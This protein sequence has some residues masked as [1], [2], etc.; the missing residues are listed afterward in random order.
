MSRRRR[1]FTLIELL[2]VIAI[3]AVLIAL[4]LP[5]V[6]AAR[7]AARRA[8]CVN[9][10]KQIGLGLHNYL[11]THNS[12]PLGSIY[13]PTTGPGVYGGQP[14]SIHAQ[15][16]GYME[17][18]PLYNCINF[19]WAP[20]VSGS[21]PCVAMHSTVRNTAIKTF[22][23]PS[24]GL[25]SHYADQ[26]APNSYDGSTGTTTIPENQV[27]SGLFS[28]DSKT[29]HNGLV[30]GM[31]SVTDG[32]SNT[33][34]FGE[35]LLGD[36]TWS[37]ELFRNDA[38]LVPIPAAAQVVDAWTAYSQVL[39]ALQLCNTTIQ[40]D[41]MSPPTGQTNDKNGAWVIGYNGITMFNT[42]VPPSSR[43]YPWGACRNGN[44]TTA[45][46][47]H[48]ANATSLHPGGAN[49]LFADGSVHFLKSSIN[50]QTYWALGTRAN[51][52]VISADSY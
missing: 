24:D 45:G 2:V 41:S 7:E 22:L 16:L 37:N 21:A 39:S 34:A 51:G 29:A 18:Q 42:I 20:W 10:M 26:G 9:N 3:I 33:I 30:C 31:A 17:A 48:F 38:A 43:Q 46:N 28:S 4:L 5:A 15:I 25:T 36:T 44:A 1:G 47:S 12:F 23:C 8:S 50:I 13:G 6:Q 49:F 19:S 11:A 27:T 32:S 14:W 40:Q 35:A 52:E